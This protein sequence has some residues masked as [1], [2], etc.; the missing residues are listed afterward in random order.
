ME[1]QHSLLRA[2]DIDALRDHGY[3][4]ARF[5]IDPFYRL[6]KRN[7]PWWFRRRC[8]AALVD[9]ERAWR[10]QLDGF[11]Q[12]VMLE[13]WLGMPHFTCSEVVAACGDRIAHYDETVPKRPTGSRQLPNELRWPG[14]PLDDYDW[15][16]AAHMDLIDADTV[17]DI[18]TIWRGTF[19]S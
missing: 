11:D 9:I 17:A 13:L 14:D 8:L 6:V 19:R 10:E 2:L 15:V 16:E 5:R 3:T 12:L 1:R 4:Y 7:P 18:G